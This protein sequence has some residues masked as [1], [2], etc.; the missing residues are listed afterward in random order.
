MHDF[1]LTIP[2]GMI[3]IFGGVVG[4][5]TSGSKPS[6]IAGVVSGSLL[7]LLGYGGYKEYKRRNGQVSSSW[8]LGSLAVSGPIAVMMGLRVQKTGKVIP[9]GLV[10]GLSIAM[11]MFYCYKL[12]T[13]SSNKAPSKQK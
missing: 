1:C 12:A 6:L 8:T 9:S 4:F 13:A 5:V 10:A 11:S 7:T 2:Y 3:M